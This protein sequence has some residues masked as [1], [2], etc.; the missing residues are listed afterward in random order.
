MPILNAD[1]IFAL[2]AFRVLSLAQ[3]HSNP[4]QL[5]AGLLNLTA[6]PGARL[7]V[8]WSIWGMAVLLP[9]CIQGDGSDALERARIHGLRVGF[10]MERPYAFVDSTGEATGESPET[11]RRLARELDIEEVQWFPIPFE[12]L[13]P[14]LEGGR[15]DVV[16]SGLFVTAER[17]QRVQFSRPTACVRPVLVQRR[18]RPGNDSGAVPIVVI[19]GSVEQRALEESGRLRSE[20]MAVP[21]LATGL[22]AVLGGSADALAISAPTARQI[23]AEDKDLVLDPAGLPARV[24]EAAQGCAAF[25]FRRADSALAVAFDSVLHE[26]VGS[27]EHLNAIRPFGFTET[28]LTCAMRPPGEARREW[29]S[30]GL[31]EPRR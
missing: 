15:I 2:A 29:T 17:Q 31:A 4:F 30:C 25:A 12:E 16:A 28:E 22:A 19:E 1:P 23:V 11:L 13:I 3:F 5:E 24:A 14:A 7:R 6:R 27:S 26:F 21:D 18:G 20:V 9:G 8:R 10:A